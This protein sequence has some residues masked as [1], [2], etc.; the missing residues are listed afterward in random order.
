MEEIFYKASLGLLII[1]FFLIRAPSVMK[2]S[3]TEKVKEKKPMRERGLVF[4]NFIGMLGL[5][6]V[7]I[8]TP[9]FDFFNIIIPEIIRF[10]G[11]AFFVIGL[12]LLT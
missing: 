10:A 11:I 9:W 7:Y 2:A 1:A 3:K 4:L 6:I 8:L 5:P 12:I